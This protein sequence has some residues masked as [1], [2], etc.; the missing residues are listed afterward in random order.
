MLGRFDG[1]NCQIGAVDVCLKPY[2]TFLNGAVAVN[3]EIYVLADGKRTEPAPT[4]NR[5]ARMMGF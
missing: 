3:T 1:E 2:E 4:V 5:I